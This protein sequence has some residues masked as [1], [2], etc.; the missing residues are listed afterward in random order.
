V[1][2]IDRTISCQSEDSPRL[3][4]VVNVSWY[5]ISH[6]FSLAQ[7]AQAAG[8][9]VHVATRVESKQDEE[10]ILECGLTLHHVEI[11]RGDSSL[12]YDFKSM[13]ALY[14]L[15]KSLCPDIIH[16]VAM[17]PVVFGGIIAR[18]IGHRSVV[19][20]IPGL[21]YLFSNSSTASGLLKRWIVG[22]MLR[23]AC[24]GKNTMIIVQNTENLDFVINENIT[25][26]EQ[27]F[28]IRGAGVDTK[29]IEITSEPKAP[30]RVVLA[31]RLLREKGIE[32]FVLAAAELK[33]RGINAEFLIAGEP[34]PSN[35]G[36]LTSDQL[37]YWH[38][39]GGIQYLGFVEDVVTLFSTC[40][41]V[42]LPSYYGEGVPKVLIEAAAC[43]RAIVTTDQPG[44]HD[45]VRDELNGILVQPRDVAS[46]ADALERI[47]EDDELRQRFGVA[48]RL[49]AQEQFDLEIV[50]GETLSV[51]ERCIRQRAT[52]DATAK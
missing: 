9:D 15:Y 32:E 10:K 42:C 28:L 21:G 43:G 31:A 2:P 38:A 33:K 14:R 51:Y 30:I 3:L 41:I 17:K 8:Y 39:S 11:G 37:K 18:M 50:L 35:P 7:A 22:A 20:A 16:H 34:D 47:I 4:L 12:I 46:L 52:M 49:L 25:V 1:S 48:G 44:C 23:V 13:L 36:S 27:S 19:Q 26:R 6:R 45:I 40:H 5:F 24:G 29:E